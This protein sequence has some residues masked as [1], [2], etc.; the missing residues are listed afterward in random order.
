MGLRGIAKQGRQVQQSGKGDEQARK[1]ARVAIRLRLRKISRV[2]EVRQFSYY[3]VL[4]S[5]KSRVCQKKAVSYHTAGPYTFIVPYSPPPQKKF[6]SSFE[7]SSHNLS[8]C[9]SNERKVFLMKSYDFSRKVMIFHE[10]IESF[11]ITNLRRQSSHNLF[12]NFLII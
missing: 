9:I 5:E 3:S 2:W 10:K 12:P 1:A 6:S 7:G 4:R 8:R 11:K